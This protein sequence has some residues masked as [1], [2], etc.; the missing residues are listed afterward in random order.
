MITIT[1]FYSLSFFQIIPLYLESHKHKYPHRLLAVGREISTTPVFDW[2]KEA[3][4]DM[5]ITLGVKCALFG[6][7]LYLQ[8]ANGETVSNETIYCYI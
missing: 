4:R 1:Q 2:L 3:M 6:V 8:L 7:F 5:G